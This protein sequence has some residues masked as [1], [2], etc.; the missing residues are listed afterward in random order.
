MSMWLLWLGL[1]AGLLGGFFAAN[2]RALMEYSP[3]R[4]LELLQRR[5]RESRISWLEPHNE[6][7]L[8]TAIYRSLFHLAVVLCMLL[9]LAPPNEQE[10]WQDY[11]LAM[12]LAWVIIAVIG[13]AV[14]MSWGR[15]AA[16]PLLIASLPI[17]RILYKL[18]HPFIWLLHPFDPIIRRLLGVPAEPTDEAASLEMQLL[19]AVS[20]VEKTGLTIDSSQKEMI[21]AVVDFT[22]TTVEQIM[23]PRTDVIGL[24]ADSSIDQIKQAI[25]EHGHSRYPVYEGDLDHIVGLLYAK[26]LLKYVGGNGDGE[27]FEIRRA[28]REALFVPE[29][30]PLQELLAEMQTRKVHIAMVLDEYGGTAG[31]VTIEDIVEEI[32]GEIQDEYETDERPEPV[33][34]RVDE[35]TALV[36]GRVYIDD[37]NDE[38]DIELP[39][40]DDYDTVGGFVFSTLGHI[41]EVGEAF[42]Y[43]NIHVTVT[44]AEKTRINQV[45]IEIRDDAKTNGN[46]E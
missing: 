2:H 44:E 33:I 22:T 11:L 15:H 20:E 38:L 12:I 23:T 30:K 13:V 46:G 45:R 21:E 4:L 1:L 28:V 24:E 7:V 25:T 40:D 34:E 16:E 6:L 9:Y 42:Q 14:P 3:S 5:K 41:P 39:E 10:A 36:E 32:V 27:P 43:E 18:T 17:L 19:D 35:R 26:D 31:L 37:L 8:T 29:T